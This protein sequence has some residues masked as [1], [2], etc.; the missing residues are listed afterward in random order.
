MSN[1]Q[2]APNESAKPNAPSD[3]KPDS[4]D[5]KNDAKKVAEQPVQK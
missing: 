2:G 5:N 3:V 1:V 4:Q